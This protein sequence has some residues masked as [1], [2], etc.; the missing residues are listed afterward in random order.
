MSVAPLFRI[1]EGR[2]DGAGAE[3]AASRTSRNQVLERAAN[4]REPR[5]LAVDVLEL[6]GRA[7]AHVAAIG[8]GVGPQRQ[9][10]FDF[11]KGEPDLLGL[12]NEPDPMDGLHRVVPEAAAFRFR[13]LFDQPLALVETDGLDADA[14]LAG[15][16]ADGHAVHC[17]HLE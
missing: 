12:P 9:Q 2:Q 10:F 14:G 5:D 11:A 16:F 7:L 4:P 1:R 17:D 13:R 15:R 3:R 6:D 8:L